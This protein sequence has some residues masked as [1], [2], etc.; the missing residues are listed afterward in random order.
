MLIHQRFGLVLHPK[1][2]GHGGLK[3][4]YLCQT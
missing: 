2:D 1:N 3:G 4:D